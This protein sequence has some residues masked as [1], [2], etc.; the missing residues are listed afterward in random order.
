M[1]SLNPVQVLKPDYYRKVYY[2]LTFR[3]RRFTKYG[4]DEFNTFTFMELIP[5][6]WI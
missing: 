1:C 4:S 5:V 3:E 6:T 2:T